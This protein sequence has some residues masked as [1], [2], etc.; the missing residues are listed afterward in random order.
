[1]NDLYTE[2]LQAKERVGETPCENDPELFF[3]DPESFNHLR[4]LKYAVTICRECPVRVEC[5]TYAIEA[6]E[7]FGVWGGL[8]PKERKLIR[9]M[10]RPR[11]PESA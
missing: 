1:M 3:T 4:T 2:L 11:L 5:A 10:P 8:T 6:G 9:Q 7:E